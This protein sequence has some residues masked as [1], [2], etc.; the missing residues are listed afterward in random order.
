MTDVQNKPLLPC[1]V[2]YFDHDD[3]NI[4]N[5]PDITRCGGESLGTEARKQYLQDN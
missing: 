1:S 3:A 5:M 4:T 2:R